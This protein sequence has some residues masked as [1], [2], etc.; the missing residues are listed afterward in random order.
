VSARSAAA[1]SSARAA[2]RA[3]ARRSPAAPA[4][5]RG[6]RPR[7]ARA[8]RA[9]RRTL[10]WVAIPLVALLLG[11]VV[12]VKAAQ[13]HLVTRTSETVQAYQAVEAEMLRLRAQLGQ[14]D[15]EV[16]RRA[17]QDLGMVYPGEVRY[18]RAEAAPTP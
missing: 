8:R 14:R 2:V 1:R 7:P 17:R 5:V 12:W 13:L 9:R 15:G 3:P 10:L 11:G 18:L 6:T 16:I 4:P